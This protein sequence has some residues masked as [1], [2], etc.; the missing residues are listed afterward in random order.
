MQGVLTRYAAHPSS[1]RLPHTTTRHPPSRRTSPHKL[2][3]RPRRSPQQGVRRLRHCPRRTDSPL[4]AAP[5]PLSPPPSRPADN[6]QILSPHVVVHPARQPSFFGVLQ[7]RELVVLNDAD[8]IP[9]DHGSTAALR[10]AAV[11]LDDEIAVFASTSPP[12]P[13]ASATPSSPIPPPSPLASLSPARAMKATPR[14]L[15][16]RLS[17]DT[18]HFATDDGTHSPMS[19]CTALPTP[20]TTATVSLRRCHR[21][22]VRGLGDVDDARA[23]STT[24]RNRD[25]PPRRR[26]EP[27]VRRPGC[28]RRRASAVLHIANLN[29]AAL[30]SLHTAA[31]F[32]S[33]TR[34]HG[35]LP[36]RPPP[37]S[38]FRDHRPRRCTSV[39]LLRPRITAHPLPSSSTQPAMHNV[40]QPIFQPM[41]VL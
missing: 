33:T 7:S 35:P 27:P 13:G 11:H 28:R 17:H 36:R 5:P 30:P 6:A 16:V 15:A 10:A 34:P 31:E 3:V 22:R 24:R 8:E 14:V 37:S 26:S 29:A 20:A 23:A 1:H 38:P 21:P 4:P 40:F 2:A 25:V 9:A 32:W 19:S 39:L 18:A 12:L 41:Y